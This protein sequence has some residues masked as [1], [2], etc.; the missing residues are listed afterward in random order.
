MKPLSSMQIRIFA[1]LVIGA[2]IAF[3]DNFSF[4]GEVSPI[5]IV[6]LLLVAAISIGA[7][8][9]WH[10]LITIALMW[11]WLPMAHVVKKVLGLPDTLHPNTYTSILMYTIFTFAVSAIGLLLGVSINK[12]VKSAR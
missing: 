10:G 4:Q 6:V 11:L 2:I 7:S 8:W 9:K 3:V 5:V 12:I 1:G